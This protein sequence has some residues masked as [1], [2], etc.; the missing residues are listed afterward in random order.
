MIKKFFKYLG[1]AIAALLLIVI[2]SVWIFFCL[3]KDWFDFND[4]IMKNDIEKMSSMIKKGY[5]INNR[6]YKQDERI[7]KGSLLNQIDEMEN[8]ANEAE[9]IIHKEINLEKNSQK[10]KQKQGLFRAKK[11]AA[12]FAKHH[13]PETDIL[14][15]PAENIG[16]TEIEKAR[17][18]SMFENNNPQLGKEIDAKIEDW[19]NTIYGTA[20]L[21][22]D[23]T[24]RQIEPAI[25]I[26]PQS[27]G[28]LATKDGLDLEQSL[29][30]LAE[31]MSEI[32]NDD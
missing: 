10:L 28:K 23:G 15:K 31:R 26:R 1:I 11:Y 24:G 32:D 13:K 9:N 5:N 18:F 6:L 27:N 3:Y 25:K 16:A 17:R 7:Y 20:P 22:R 4:A 30:K 19:Y 14:L 29:W 2:V 21:R 12:L 8:S